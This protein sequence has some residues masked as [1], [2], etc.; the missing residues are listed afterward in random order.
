[1]IAMTS[2]STL[3][4]QYLK[5]TSV[6]YV[7]RYLGQSVSTLY[8]FEN[9]VSPHIAAREANN[10]VRKPFWRPVCKADENSLT[11]TI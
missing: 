8:Q 2:Q 10:V 5:L 11:T 1:M 3:A 9:P 7:Q 4:I 6:S